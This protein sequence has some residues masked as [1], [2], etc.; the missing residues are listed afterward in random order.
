MDKEQIYTAA[1]KAALDTLM[2]QT[3]IKR[4]GIADAIAKAIVAALAEYDKQRS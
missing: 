2:A 4:E 1:N 3:V